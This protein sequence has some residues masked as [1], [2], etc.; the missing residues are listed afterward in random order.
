METILDLDAIKNANDLGIIKVDVPE[1]GGVV[2]IKKLSLKETLGLYSKYFEVDGKINKKLQN[3][4]TVELLSK[5]LC[6]PNG[7]NII[8]DKEVLL[9]K[10][11]DVV[12]ALFNKCNDHC[13]PSNKKVEDAEKK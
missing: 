7:K 1:W 13:L 3:E 6:D 12:M 10:S 8:D 11:S 4:F 5:C 9:N 2:F